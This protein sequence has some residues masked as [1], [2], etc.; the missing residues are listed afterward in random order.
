MGGCTNII[1]EVNTHRHSMGTPADNVSHRPSLATLG[2]I[3]PAKGITATAYAAAPN[4]ITAK[5]AAFPSTNQHVPSQVTI[6]PYQV[7]PGHIIP[8]L[9]SYWRWRV[10]Q[11]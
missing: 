9:H 6:V 4:N 11:G 5:Q 2:V 8:D 3:H 1:S 7:T 10:E